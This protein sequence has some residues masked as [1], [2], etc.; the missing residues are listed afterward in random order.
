FD[1][2]QQTRVESF[3]L[4]GDHPDGGIRL[5]IKASFDNPSTIGIELGAVEFEP[6]FK[7]TPLGLVTVLGL[8]MKPEAT[9]SMTM[10]G[11]M[12]PQTDADDLARVSELMSLF[13]SGKDVPVTVHGRSAKAMG[14]R[15]GELLEV[16][17]LNA[18]FQQLE[19]SISLPGSE[20]MDIIE[21]ISLEDMSLEFSPETA[22]APRMS[23]KDI[24]AT[25]KNPFGFSLGIHKIKEDI[26]LLSAGDETPMASLQLPL[27]T[28]ESEGQVIHTSFDNATMTVFGN[29]HGAF[30]QFVADLTVK[31]EQAVIFGGKVDTVARTP[32]GEVT[33]LGIPIH[34]QTVL[35]GLNGLKD[36]PTKVLSVDVTG[37]NHDYLSIELVVLMTNPSKI[38]IATRG[39]IRFNV[40]VPGHSG[41]LGQA[42]LRDLQLAHGENEVKAIFQFRPTDASLGQDFLA[43]YLRGEPEIPVVI[44]GADDATNIPSLRRAFSS[45]ALD[46]TIAGNQEQLLVECHAHVPLLTVLW[47]GKVRAEVVVHNPFK[48]DMHV[49]EISTKV[50]YKGKTM[51]EVVG[52]VTENF[53]IPGDS[54]GQ[55]PTLEMEIDKNFSK[56]SLAGRFEISADVT[57]SGKA[58]VG[59]SPETGYPL[60][61]DYKQEGLKYF[62]TE[63]QLL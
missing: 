47:K 12:K 39:Y 60:T 30:D 10:S 7:G 46:S 38:Q 45:L 31:S 8:Q 4:P 37:G 53:T 5:D 24:A 42:V 25:Y 29:A 17:W 14:E 9:A 15:P 40:G 6:R 33:L 62:Y 16:E 34:T 21:G 49:L 32:I 55:S 50:T 54:T 27:Q 56:L 18:A 20:G 58:V 22:Y 44:A 36:V 3:D 43:R 35:E 51:C 26:E 61:V 1:G 2:L 52:M 63:L 13:I 11:Q 48:A 57:F 41:N 59:E 23:S 28:V 19:L